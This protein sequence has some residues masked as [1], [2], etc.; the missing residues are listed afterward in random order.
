MMPTVKD[1]MATNVITIDIQ[2][3]VFELQS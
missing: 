1:F 3:T 2:E